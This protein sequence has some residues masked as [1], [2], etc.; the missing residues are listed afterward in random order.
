MFKKVYLDNGIPL[1]MEKVEGVRSVA[2]G[3]WVKV[4]ARF[5]APGK[6]GISHFVEHMF[7]KGTKNR[8]QKAIA[9][10]ID[11]LG[12]DLNAFTSRESTTFYVKLLSDYVE[13]GVDV[14]ADIFFNS[15]FKE[16]DIEK[17]QEI[18]T[19]EIMMVEDTPDDYIHDLF[20]QDIWGLEGLGMPVLGTKE[21]VLSFGREDLLT[22]IASYYCH[23][24]VVISCAGNIDFDGYLRM[25]NDKF[26]AAKSLCP[27]S[28]NMSLSTFGTALKVYEKDHS[29]V[30]MCIGVKGVKQ[31]SELRYPF[32]VLNTIFGSG[33]SSRLF[34]EVRET[35]GLVYTIYS[36]LSSYHDT[37][38]F[39][40][41]AGA[42]R[43]KYVEVI[44]T[45]IKEMASLKETITDKEIERAKNQIKG[46]MLMSLESSSGR[47]HNIARQEIYYGRYYP[48]EEIISGIEK[49]LKSDV[50]GII[51][52]F[53]STGGKAVTVLG[54]AKAE[55]LSGIV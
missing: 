28:K 39:A 46:N 6:N 37:G 50:A 27:K 2:V 14:L 53:L 32:L 47:M 21:T 41:Y 25:F 12:G 9:I 22:H 19:E 29:E 33:V 10:E 44:E 5:E 11:S 30:H 20:Y 48:P 18:I 51:D 24:D 17:E 34:Q 23:D 43:K 52:T 7:F 13:K 54:P 1:V 49:V 45:V 31:D 36:F 42:G 8:S 26:G 55:E 35:R 15:L 4:G 40:V 38:V 16:E 3:I